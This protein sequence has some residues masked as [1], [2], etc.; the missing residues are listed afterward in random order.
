MFGMLWINL[1]D[2]AFQF[3]PISSDFAVIED[4]WDNIPQTTINSLINSLYPTTLPLRYL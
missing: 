2:S 1:Y 4:E 3:P